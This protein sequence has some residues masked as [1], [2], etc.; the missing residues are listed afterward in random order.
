MVSRVRFATTVG[1]IRDDFEKIVADAV[2]GLV[3]NG[4]DAPRSP[5]HQQAPHDA[6]GREGK[7][8]QAHAAEET[9]KELV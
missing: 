4:G 5:Q 1:G 7:A 8:E 6:A 3:V 9:G 2:P